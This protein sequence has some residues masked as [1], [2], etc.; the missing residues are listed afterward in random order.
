MIAGLLFLPLTQ[1][2]RPA[3]AP[4]PLD[5]PLKGWCTYTDAGT[6]DQPYSIVFLYVPWRELEPERGRFAFDAWERRAWNV[7]AARG[8]HVVFRVYVD[9][10]GKATGLPAWLIKEGVKLRPYKEYGGG[11]APDYNDPRTVAAMERLIAALGKRYNSHPR[12]AFIQFGLLGFWGE[13]HTYP[14]PELFA[15]A[16]TE[17]KVLDAARRAFPD[18]KVMNRYPMGYAGRQRWL[19][20]FDDMFP[21]DTDGKE[22]WM[23]LPR[24][25]AAG[26][27]EA[28]KTVPFGGEMVPHAAKRW[29]GEGFGTT[30]KRL[31]ESHFSWVG[32]YSPAIAG[33]R[34]PSL[35]ARSREMVRRMGYEYRLEEIRLP[36]EVAAGGWLE[37]EV[38]G[39][40]QGVAPFYYPWRVQMGLRDLR[41]RIVQRWTVGTDIRT[42]LPGAF[43]FRSRA[44]AAVNG[45][46]Y[47]VVIGVEDPWSKKPAIGFANALRRRDGW[48]EVAEVL[49]RG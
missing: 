11:S 33:L 42:W 31:E 48:T 41:G 29:L 39:R 32:P 8:K 49:I 12:V 18:K 36:R 9:Y 17:V 4:G 43:R 13:W 47:D 21:E 25:R 10:P 28:W 15:N 26:R 19:G 7:P 46:R 14:R 27:E 35:V 45:G 30:M 34:E 24:L 20:F 3:P 44:Q 2:V 5:N 22:D 1:V 23:F 37:V 6:I 40:N 38:R 16:A